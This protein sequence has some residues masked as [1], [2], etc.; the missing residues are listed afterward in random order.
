LNGT[1]DSDRVVQLIQLV[2]QK[3]EGELATI[4]LKNICAGITSTDP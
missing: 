3:S 1:K 2:D 4:E